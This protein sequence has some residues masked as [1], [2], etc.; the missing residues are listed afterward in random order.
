MVE[1]KLSSKR[2]FAPWSGYGTFS[3]G[4]NHEPHPADQQ[5]HHDETTKRGEPPT[6]ILVGLYV[7]FVVRL[8][9]TIVQEPG[10]EK[11]VGEEPCHTPYLGLL[12]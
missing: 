7:L 5:H 3:E 4:S 1:T 8:V 9:V 2:R 12:E 11:E 10:P 6:R